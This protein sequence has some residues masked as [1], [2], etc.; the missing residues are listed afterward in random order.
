[1]QM[2]LENKLTILVNT[3]DGY[4]DLWMPFFTLLKRYW[5]PQG[6]PILLNT[7]SKEFSMDGLDITCV[8]AP[9]NRYYGERMLY[10]LSQVK[11]EYVLLLLDDFFLRQAV[12][13]ERIHQILSWMEADR[14]IA[15]FNTEA[16]PVYVDWERDRYPGFRRVPPG[17]AY[18]LNM[19]AALWRTGMLKRYWKPKVS[20]WEWEAYCNLLQYKFPQQK[21]Y[22]TTDCCH[23]FLDYGHRQ[24]GDVWAVVRGKWVMEDVQPLFQKENI[25]VDLSRRGAYVPGQPAAQQEDTRS[26]WYQ[27][28]LRSLGLEGVVWYL[29]YKV[30][31][32]FCSLTGKDC[33]PDFMLWLSD[34]ARKKF[35]KG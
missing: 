19:Q 14:N 31:Y 13:T 11:T 21:I 4:E 12:Q 22:C 30:Y 7:E 34:N 18:A 15:C 3:C 16:I 28:L 2:Q 1:M 20:P 24:V 32:K 6:I 23:S 27:L 5:N 8:H 29:A 26:S 9:R 17:T 35:L 10:A 25:A 33:N